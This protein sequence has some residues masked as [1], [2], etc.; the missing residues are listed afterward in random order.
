MKS[1]TVLLGIV[2][3]SATLP[4]KTTLYYLATEPGRIADMGY[5]FENPFR[6]LYQT[7]LHSFNPTIIA[8]DDFESVD[9]LNKGDRLFLRRVFINQE[10]GSLVVA[11]VEAKMQWFPALSFNRTFDLVG[12]GQLTKP[13]SSPPNLLAPPDSEG[14]R[15]LR[16]WSISAGGT[17]ELWDRILPVPTSLGEEIP[18]TLSEP[19]LTIENLSFSFE[20]S[21]AYLP[22]HD[23]IFALSPTGTNDLTPGMDFRIMT[24][25]AAVGDYLGSSGTPSYQA[26]IVDQ[27]HGQLYPAFGVLDP[28][29][30]IFRD[31]NIYTDPSTIGSPHTITPGISRIHDTSPAQRLARFDLDGDR[32]I[33]F[34]FLPQG[35]TQGLEALAIDP[36]QG[37]LFSYNHSLKT[38]IKK[39]LNRPDSSAKAQ[40]SAAQ[41]NTPEF[42]WKQFG[43]ETED[44]VK[45][46]AEPVSKRL[47][48]LLENG[49]LHSINYD[50]SSPALETTLPANTIEFAVYNDTP[51]FTPPLAATISLSGDLPFDTD[52]T[53]AVDLSADGSIVLGAANSGDETELNPAFVSSQ[54][55]TLLGIDG[56]AIAL[57]FPRKDPVSEYISDPIA[58]SGDGKT[59]IIDS[60]LGGANAQP[61]TWS[62][63]TGIITRDDYGPFFLN[64]AWDLSHDGLIIVGSY[65]NEPATWS[66]SSGL[67]SFT[68]PPSRNEEGVFTAVDR[69]GTTFGGSATGGDTEA[70]V[71]SEE[72]GYILL[73]DLPG[74]IFGSEVRAL[75]PDGKIA[76]GFSYTLTEA[77]FEL[78]SPFIWTAENGLQNLGALDDSSPFT[79]SGL[80]EG[81][82]NHQVVVGNS[83]GRAFVYH[84]LVGIISLSE[85]ASNAYGLDLSNVSLLSAAAIS[86]DSKTIV[87]QANAD[88]NLKGYQITIPNFPADALLLT[89]G[90]APDSDSDGDSLS[91]FYE[92]ATG[93]DPF[94]PSSGSPSPLQVTRSAGVTT[95]TFLKPAIASSGLISYTIETAPTLQGPWTTTGFTVVTDSNSE[96][97]VTYPPSTRSFFRL[98]MSETP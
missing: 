25:P 64:S 42:Q 40:L 57:G 59:A 11:G 47:F 79:I 92:A 5:E 74:G 55:A 38:L 97:T 34:E 50:G 19:G 62:A 66:A 26:S 8:R 24:D 35:T 56:N 3:S 72:S 58:I 32:P 31:A 63:K 82:N 22:L 70:F 73:G 94:D 48:F 4:G 54:Q 49:E 15:K 13:F 45:L 77:G 20:K 90:L 46:Q 43:P 36:Y 51:L 52:R 85:F 93:T 16:L 7:D 30:V 88:G 33:V 23:K 89:S 39:P 18:L 28:T 95:L 10:N 78:P 65:G 75:S 80:A 53:R 87:G 81:V 86:D 37:L 76:A 68:L 91:D 98:V 1:L 96:L 60:Y 9:E 27:R 21:E 12:G 44:I 17:S 2:L 41:T 69:D 83:G 71:Y 29:N 6:A 67:K 14:T 84:P 61:A